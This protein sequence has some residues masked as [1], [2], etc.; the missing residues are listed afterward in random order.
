ME[1]AGYLMGALVWGG[2]IAAVPAT[3]GG[4]LVV[5]RWRRRTIAA[6]E[7]AELE[8]GPRSPT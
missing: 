3:V 8:E 1:A 2:A 5:V 4:S 6:L 7:R